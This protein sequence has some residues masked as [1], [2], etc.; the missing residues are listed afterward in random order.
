MITF[1]EAIK[2]IVANVRLTGGDTREHSTPPPDL[3]QRLREYAVQQMSPHTKRFSYL[4]LEWFAEG[5]FNELVRICVVHLNKLG[6][7]EQE[8]MYRILT[9]T[10]DAV[11]AERHYDVRDETEDFEEQI[12]WILNEIWHQMGD[13]QTLAY[14]FVTERLLITWDYQQSLWKITNLGE[15]FLELSP[16]QGATFVLSIDTLF[17]TG[18]R[19]FRHF[20]IQLLQRLL[21]GD[22]DKFH[23]FL[24]HKDALFRLGIIMESDEDLRDF[25]LTPI[26][27]IVL[28]RVLDKD[29]P[30]RDAASTL[31]KT[32]ELGTTFKRTISEIDDILGIVKEHKLVDPENQESINTSVTLYQQG[33]YLES[34]RIIFPSIEA[35][36]NVMLIDE[37]EQPEHFRGLVNKAQWLEQ[38]K[39]I[40]LDVSGAMEVFSGRNKVLHGNFSPPSD[41]VFPLCLLAFRYLRRL[42]TE[43]T[44]QK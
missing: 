32:E 4:L 22:V 13:E 27:K 12:A 33:K 2:Y 15:F 39:L 29:N 35:I 14:T 30:L 6:I 43:Y 36:I 24:P 9:K 3:I 28:E 7:V 37:G 40:P 42:L 34:L 18:E 1:F 21:D 23:L 31:I 38:H 26:G 19:D 20:N 16:V 41:Y 10:I 5:F 17:S 8:K 11:L 44:P 25:K